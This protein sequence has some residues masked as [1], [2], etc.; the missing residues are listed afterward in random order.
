MD[1]ARNVNWSKP[2]TDGTNV[3]VMTG[4]KVA[5]KSLPSEGVRDNESKLW[6]KED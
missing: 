6:W 1:L 3:V 2:S 4:A 5:D